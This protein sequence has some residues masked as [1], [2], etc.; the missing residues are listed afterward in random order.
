[1]CTQNRQETYVDKPIESR[2][3]NDLYRLEVDDTAIRKTVRREQSSARINTKDSIMV[4]H[5]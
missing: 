4:V 1:M 5:K 2:G 3:S